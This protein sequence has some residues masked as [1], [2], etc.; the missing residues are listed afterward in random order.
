MRVE[1]A[2]GIQGVMIKLKRQR[3]GMQRMERTETMTHSLLF[4]NSGDKQTANRAGWLPKKTPPE[5]ADDF[6]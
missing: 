2:G 1:S 3:L 4:N 6:L 5:A